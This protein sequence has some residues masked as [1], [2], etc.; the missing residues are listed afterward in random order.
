MNGETKREEIANSITHGIGA[1]L[2]IAA[3]S[4]LVVF[5]GLRGDAWRVVSVSIYGATL[6]L[7]YLASTFYH[8]FS[9]PRVKRVFHVF[10][11]SAI[12]LLIAGSY[13]PFCLVT[14]RGGWG[15]SLFGVV[16]GI[17][18]FG[19]VFK[20]FSTGR[21][22]FVSTVLYIAMGWI[23]VIAIKPLVSRLPTGAF[24]WILLG[25]LSYTV[26]VIF[27]AWERLPYSHAI[28]HLFVLGGST[29]HF[30][31]VLFYVLPM[32]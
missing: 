17:A 16:W 23:A 9:N 29:L 24:A 8:V 26:G 11:H 3:L 15:W 6:V 4:V 21:Y 7:L 13:T 30:F 31:A 32:A 2:S 22:N 14:I 1:A 18:I 25:G 19:I 10:D 5:A 20:A 12:F 27:Y 28:W